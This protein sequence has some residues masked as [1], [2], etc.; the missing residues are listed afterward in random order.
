[1]KVLVLGPS[2]SGKT[3]ISHTLQDVGINVFDGDDI[4]GLSAWYDQ[5]W[6]KVPPPLTANEAI[7]NHYSF[8]WDKSFLAAFLNKFPDVYIFGGSGNVFDTFELFDKI[9]FLKVDPELQKTRIKNSSRKNPMMDMNENSLVVWGEW[10]EVQ[11]KQRNIP[12][13]DASQT[14]AQIFNIISKS[15][16]S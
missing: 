16:K 7:N 14:P 5:H 2:G 12:F 8:I 4:E 9:Y 13:L 1:M 3:Y 15:E 10:F 6:K 11:A